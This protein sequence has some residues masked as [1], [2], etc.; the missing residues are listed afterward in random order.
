MKSLVYTILVCLLQIKQL[1]SLVVT[2]STLHGAL[3]GLVR[4][5]LLNVFL[6]LSHFED[7]DDDDDD[8]VDDEDCGDVSLFG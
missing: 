2:F 5:H 1:T 6:H 4:L 3:V 7:L 8:A